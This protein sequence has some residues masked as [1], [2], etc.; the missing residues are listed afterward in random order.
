M[1]ETPEDMH[2]ARRSL[3]WS[4]SQ[5]ADALRLA[6]TPK[7][8]ADYVRQMESGARSISGPVTVAVEAFLTGFRPEGFTESGPDRI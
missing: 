7:S 2:Q 6:G 3:G 1:I 8:S 4:V 5:M